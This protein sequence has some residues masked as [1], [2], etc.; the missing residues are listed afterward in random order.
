MKLIF[1]RYNFLY[2]KKVYFTAKQGVDMIKK[3]ILFLIILPIFSYSNVFK[4]KKPTVF[5]FKIDPFEKEVINNTIP[6]INQILIAS[7]VPYNEIEKYKKSYLKLI[8][9]F[10]TKSKNK[11]EIADQL[12][13]YLHYKVMKQYKEKNN[14]FK[15]LF[16]K[17]YYNCV[18]SS[19][20]YNI[21]AKNLGLEPRGALLSD[22]VLSQ[23]KI[24]GK[25]VDAE[26]TVAFGF[27]AGNRR[28][29]TNEF[30]KITGFVYVPSSKRGK[31]IQ[32]ISMR[33]YLA[34]LLSNRAVE[35]LEK[36]YF[37][38]AFNTIF[39]AL[40]IF[41]DFPEGIKNLQAIYTDYAIYLIS[42]KRF[43]IAEQALIETLVYT[44][45]FKKSE[46]NLKALYIQWINYLFDSDKYEEG[47]AILKKQIKRFKPS[48]LENYFLLWAQSLIK[49][50]KKHEKALI[51][52]EKSKNYLPHSKNL[53]DYKNYIYQDYINFLKT[54][55]Q[56]NKAI[57]ILIKISKI[58]SLVVFSAIELLKLK[59]LAEANTLLQKSYEN[60]KDL[61][62]MKALFQVS[63]DF[64]KNSQYDL[65]KNQ[66]LFFA[67]H[68]NDKIVRSY[69]PKLFNQ[70]TAYLYQYRKID[71]GIN[72]LKLL[73]N[74]NYLTPFTIKS[75]GDLY[76]NSLIPTLKKKQFLKALPQLKKGV[77]L[78]QK[79]HPL[80][81]ETYKNVIINIGVT[82]YQQKKITKAYQ[83]YLKI[84]KEFSND[85]IVRNN[86]RS[87]AGVYLEKLKKS[88]LSLFRRTKKE[89]EKLLK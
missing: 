37:I 4:N 88:N 43:S 14:S 13:K 55:N 71:F 89:V 33:K 76:Y 68:K 67:K 46:H 22:H 66:L 7:G 36:K 47:I 8:N 49:K 16:D 77:L 19:L 27:D 26:T 54:N 9:N 25:W 87:V 84:M 24:N 12:L 52:L 39:K 60:K 15:D 17:G 63:F 5:N 34:L 64:L 3:I 23:I 83:W 62:K 6:L 80:L 75:I 59:R 1:S 10:K 45:G 48:Q 40:I 58:D 53:S 31:S 41:P 11:Y 78:T 2:I 38:K 65:L 74:N 86:F 56:N 70:L 50:H 72:Y 57:D 79:K 61:N 29:A 21:A 44:P 42:Q 85:N 69:L 18:T 30:K 32:V 20:F 51:V 28:K 81:L 35:Y 82:Y 73:Q